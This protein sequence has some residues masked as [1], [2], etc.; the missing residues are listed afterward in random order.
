MTKKKTYLN[1]ITKRTMTILS[2]QIQIHIGKLFKRSYYCNNGNQFEGNRTIYTLVD[3]T[4]LFGE[5]P[6]FS[7]HTAQLKYS[8]KLQI[9]TYLFIHS[10]VHSSIH[11]FFLRIHN[12]IASR[13]LTSTFANSQIF[14][15]PIRTHSFNDKS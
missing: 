13:I 8:L 9:S 2:D 1:E 7:I 4:E 5:T 3:T 6:P 12:N 10:T 15:S 11:S 14:D